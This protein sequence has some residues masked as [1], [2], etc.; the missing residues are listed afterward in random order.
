MI[1]TLATS[2][3]MGGKKKFKILKKVLA[4]IK[5]KYNVQNDDVKRTRQKLISLET[6]SHNRVQIRIETTRESSKQAP[7]CEH[8]G[9]KPGIK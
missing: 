4:P 2:Q 7:L 5:P 6:E 9:D 1:S 3:N 8:I